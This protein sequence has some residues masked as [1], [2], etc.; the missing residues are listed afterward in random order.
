MRKRMIISAVVVLGLVLLFFGTW[1]VGWLYFRI[2]SAE[3]ALNG[4]RSG[5]S[6]VYRAGTGDYLIVLDAGHSSHQV[7]AVTNRGGTVGIP[8]SPIPSSYT[9]SV[10]SGALVLC[11]E[12]QITA[13]GT[14]KL[15]GSIS[16]SA[17][18]MDFHVGA[19]SVTVKF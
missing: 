14:D 15:A 11:L 18:Q 17:N 16:A 1:K 13:A 8:G 12:C 3:V 2:S 10:K 9:K 6:E 19:D 7:Y 4:I 5:E